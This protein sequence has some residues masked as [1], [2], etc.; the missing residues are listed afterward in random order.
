MFQG[1]DGQSLRE[2]GGGGGGVWVQ[3]EGRGAGGRTW[4][5]M[6]AVM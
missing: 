4:E 6:V 5:R 3:D 2:G 1:V